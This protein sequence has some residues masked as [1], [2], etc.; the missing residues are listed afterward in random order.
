MSQISWILHHIKYCTRYWGSNGEQ[1]QMF[2]CS[3]G[4]QFGISMCHDVILLLLSLFSFLSLFLKI[5]ST[6][7]LSQPQAYL[8][9]S[10]CKSSSI[11]TP[12]LKGISKMGEQEK[13]KAGRGRWYFSPFES[14]QMLLY[15]SLWGLIKADEV[16]ALFI[17]FLS[18]LYRKFQIVLWVI[19][20]YVVS[21]AQPWTFLLLGLGLTVFCNCQ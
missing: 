3:C 19:L 10:N 16:G 1:R 15:V 14:P 18:P 12:R 20:F 11:R 8:S 13:D 5:Y 2:S 17:F 7:W 4:P 6:C 21:E 9:L